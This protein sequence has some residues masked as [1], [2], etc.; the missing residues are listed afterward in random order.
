[1]PGFAG[2]RR[3]FVVAD[4]LAPVDTALLDPAVVGPDAQRGGRGAV[5]DTCTRF[6]DGDRAAHRPRISTSASSVSVPPL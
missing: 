5:G 3:P 1:M 6:F 2:P 4:H